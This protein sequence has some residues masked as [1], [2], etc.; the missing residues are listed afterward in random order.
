MSRFLPFFHAPGIDARAFHKRTAIL[1]NQRARSTDFDGS[2]TETSL[3]SRKTTSSTCISA[4]GPPLPSLASLSRLARKRDTRLAQRF[5]DTR[6]G[7]RPA[8]NARGR[9]VG[10][11]QFKC[12]TLGGQAHLIGGHLGANGVGPGA[13]VL[14]GGGADARGGRRRGLS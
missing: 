12:H 1:R 11:A 10:V 4:K 7:G 9:Q 13:E 14:R 5:G 3:L 8:R 2:L 6:R